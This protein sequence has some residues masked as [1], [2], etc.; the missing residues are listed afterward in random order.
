MLSSP[1]FISC[2]QASCFNVSFI[3]VD[4]INLFNISSVAI[5]CVKDSMTHA[6]E[7]DP[8]NP[9]LCLIAGNNRLRNYTV[10]RATRG[11]ILKAIG[12]GAALG[13]NIVMFGHLDT[14]DPRDVGVKSRVFGVKTMHI[15]LFKNLQCGLSQKDFKGCSVIRRL[16][17]ARL[18]AL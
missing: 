6:P 8:W 4:R 5:A 11:P 7:C 18:D 16:R 14:T 10:L 15:V 2:L 1:I 17:F 3:Q 13:Q 12:G 9:Q